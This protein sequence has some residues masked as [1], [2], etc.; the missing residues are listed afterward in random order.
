MLRAVVFNRVVL[1]I[2][3][4]VILIFAQGQ[5]GFISAAAPAA[6]MLHERLA[7]QILCATVQFQVNYWAVSPDECGY[8]I[9]STTGYGTVKEGRYLVTHNHFSPP[10]PKNPDVDAA[11]IY[12]Q[13]QIYNAAGS[14]LAELPY[15]RVKIV[16]QGEETLA[17]DFGERDGIGFF[18]AL[19]FASAEFLD[20]QDVPLV[21]HTV[22]AQVDWDGRKARVDWTTVLRVDVV[23]GVTRFVVADP[24]MVGASGGGLFWHGYHV[25][26]NWTTVTAHDQTGAIIGGYSTAALNSR[27]VVTFH[28]ETGEAQGDLSLAAYLNPSVSRIVDGTWNPLRESRPDAVSLMAS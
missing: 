5:A 23:E 3:T 20:G 28:A 22:L 24:L 16:M 18:E 11:A 7:A 19:Q 1:L 13:V 21:P 8:M 25:A 9:Q 6:S 26:N 10:F 2:I 4:A 12:G 27:Q 14:K 15:D 17:L